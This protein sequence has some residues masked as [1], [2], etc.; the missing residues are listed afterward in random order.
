MTW[1]EALILGIIQ[2]LTEFF[3]VSSSGHLVMGSRAMGLRL[4][5]I[6]F[7]VAVHVATLVSVIVVY[8][9]RIRSLLL[10]LFGHS[11]GDK[12]A[13][14]YA[15][16]LVLVSLPA[17]LVGILFKDWFESRFDDPDFSATMIM[18]SGCLV[19]SIRWTRANSR[20]TALELLPIGLVAAVTLL[21]GTIIPFLIVMG[22]TA[23]I[24]GA[25]RAT[26]L[27]QW[28]VRPTW[29]SALFIGTAQAMAILPGITR[30][31]S[32][33]LAGI[34]RRIDPVAAAEFSF[35]MSIIAISAAGLLMV[36]DAMETGEAIGF[37]PLIV[38]CLAALASGILA[39]RFFLTMLRR[40]SFHVFA[41]YCWAIGGL[42]LFAT[43]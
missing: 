22:V 20:I 18:V 8:R 5:G 11:N 9:Q 28:H 1:L 38:G 36:P 35:L 21:A 10:G 30:S 25:A 27:R 33:V 4:P 42:F 39:I 34:W 6:V 31:G 14:S 29:I 37:G 23:I 16:R 43:R 24:L 17:G 41:Y 32:T 13:R 40:Q 3:P 2:G 12:N 26:A 19:W 7:E 15:L